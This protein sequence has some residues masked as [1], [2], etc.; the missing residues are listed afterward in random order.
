MP[1]QGLPQLTTALIR[2]RPGCRLRTNRPESLLIRGDFCVDK[3]PSCAEMAD[4]GTVIVIGCWFTLNVIIS[5]LNSWVL[6]REKFSYPVLLTVVH[7]LACRMLSGIALRSVMRPTTDR[8]VSES[9]L[10]KVRL[11]ALSFC[12]SVACGNIALKYIFVSFAQMVTAATPLFTMVLMYVVA[13]KR[14]SAAS[15]ASMLPMCGGVMLCTAGELNFN[16]LGFAAVVSASLFRGLKSI[17]QA[18]LLTTEDERLSSL[19]L[20]YHMSGFSVFPLLAYTLLVE[21]PALRDPRLRGQ[22]SL[23]LW[24]LVLLSGGVSFLLNIANFLVT[25]RTSAVTLQ[26]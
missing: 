14:Y 10:S 8:P 20:L 25:K 22:Q 16:A 9:T 13:G 15:Y 11:L 17:Q 19:E 23:R 1:I 7:M 5:N 4:I 18:R 21:S 24:G 2:T 3:R 26:V 12:A 6:K